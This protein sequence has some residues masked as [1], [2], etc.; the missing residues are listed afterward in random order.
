MPAA[1]L[2]EQA[3]RADMHAGEA[4][5]ACRGTANAHLVFFGEDF[6]SLRIAIDEEGGQALACDLREYL[7]DTGPSCVRDELLRAIERRSIGLERG[8]GRSIQRVTARAGLG[9]RVRCEHF[10]RAEF[11][12]VLADQR[13]RARQHERLHP[14]PLV[15]H[16]RD[17]ERPGAAASI[18][19]NGN[20]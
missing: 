1:D 12:D 2:A 11:C 14:D 16:R 10:R 3:I 4:Q 8:G 15:H 20:L 17:A 13:L 7:E 18:N 6:E 9:Q 5:R 19:F